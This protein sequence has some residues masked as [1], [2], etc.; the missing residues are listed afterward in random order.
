MSKNSSDENE[1]NLNIPTLFIAKNDGDDLFL[2]VQKSSVTINANFALTKSEKVNCTFWL[3]SSSPQSMKFMASFKE[4]YK[5]YARNGEGSVNFD[6]HYTGLFHCKFCNITNY[7][8]YPDNCISGGRFCSA[9]PEGSNS[10]IAPFFILEDLRQLCL[11]KTN[12]EAWWKYVSKFNKKCQGN[13]AEFENCSLKQLE[14]IEKKLKIQDLAQKILKCFNDSFVIPE[15]ETQ[16]NIMSHDNILLQKERK[17]SIEKAIEFWPSVTLNDEIYKGNLVGDLVF[18]AICQS[19]ENLPQFCR[20]DQVEDLINR[21]I[22]IMV[23]M[24]VAFIAI[25]VSI[26]YYTKY[27]RIKETKLR[28][29]EISEI[30]GKYHVLHENKINSI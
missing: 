21:N 14:K 27:K 19:F 26:I 28:A 15:N 6:V 1:L 5:N 8:Y 13:P 30:I 2:K 29:F 16:I 22:I 12:L 3:T 25:V 11:Y 7:N 17:I 23:L 9:Y 20:F 24:M 4:Y 10:S 18:S